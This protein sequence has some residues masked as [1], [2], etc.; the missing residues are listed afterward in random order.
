MTV[1]HQI[2]SILIELLPE[3]HGGRA[4]GDSDAVGCAEH[5]LVPVSER[6]R[7]MIRREILFQPFE[8][9]GKPDARVRAT[10]RL[11]LAFDV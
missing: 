3:G 10:A 5:G 8:F 6:A 2:R 9:G 7:G 11:C 4:L 1:Q